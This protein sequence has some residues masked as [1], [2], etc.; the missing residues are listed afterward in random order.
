MK[1]SAANKNLDNNTIAQ[2][3]RVQYKSGNRSVIKD[4]VVVEQPLQISIIWPNAVKPFTFSITLRTPCDD[5][6]LIVGLLFSEGVISAREDIIS[7]DLLEDD[8]QP[9]LK[10]QWQVALAAHCQ[11]HVKLLTQFMQT[12]SSCGLCGS[13]SIRSLINK[14]PKKLPA[15]SAW[16]DVDVITKV[17]RIM[18][19]Q[20]T[21]FKQTGGI[22]GAALFNDTSLVLLKEDI[23][24]HNALDKVIGDAWL[25]EC[26]Y[27][28]NNIL[29]ITSRVS[30]EMVQKAVM[31]NVPVLIALGAVSSLAI[32]TAQQFDLTL[33]GFTKVDSF[34]VYCGDWRINSG[35]TS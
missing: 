20:Q 31:A 9:N 15:E 23:G 29:V 33:I 8:E 16:L 11:E 14:Q 6:S 13:T 24:R 26:L 2:V 5:H 4:S 10:N 21:L 30:F 17:P 3:N 35:S 32:K 19:K 34:N 1:D 25:Q 22:H 27:Q 12:Y 7:I 28:P 18:C